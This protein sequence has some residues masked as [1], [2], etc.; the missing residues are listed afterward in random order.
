MNR[1]KKI[2]QTSIIGIIVNT[3]L[4]AFKMGV[5]L[6]AGS[7]SIIL[8]AVNNFSDALSSAITIIG[9][10]LSGK[11]PDKKHPYGYGRIE[12]VTS[13]IIAVIVLVAGISSAKESV[14]NIFHP[15]ETSFSI[16]SLVIIAVAIVAKLAVGLYVKK[17]GK[18]IRSG[19]LIASG[20]DA[21]FDAVLSTAT[22]V[23]AILSFV[24]G[25]NVE[26]YLGAVISVFIIK[27]GIEMLLE[28][29]HSI[30]GERADKELTDALTDAIAAH[31]GVRGVY[32]LTVHNYG[33]NQQMATAHIELSDATTAK[34]I[35]LLTRQ[36]AMEIFAQFGIILTL[37]IYASNDST[38][39]SREIKESA[40]ALV[41]QHSEI[42][43]MHGFYVDEGT[44]CVM[45]DLII[46]FKADAA[47]IQ[48]QLQQ[49]LAAQ[50]PEYQFDIVL[51]SDYSDIKQE[52][53][54]G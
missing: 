52:D 21:L 14:T 44:R 38:P 53:T 23:S 2:I 43:Q 35:H 22:L 48:Q 13:A 39:E 51:D 36:I 27:A 40:R 18:A 4:V 3:L 46:D 33:P 8:D 11:K 15:T 16:V 29:L 42:L 9:T 32:D 49:T 19:S 41:A 50:Y 45:F 54:N 12:Y 6:I 24:W 31:E 20:S 30:I 26:G 25:I 47:S 5:G 1:A 34:T 28:T 10:K 17:V 7:I 37:G